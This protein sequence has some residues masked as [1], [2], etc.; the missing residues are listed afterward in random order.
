MYQICDNDT[1][2]HLTTATTLRDAIEA[3]IT[4]HQQYLTQLRTNGEGSTQ[5]RLATRVID[6]QTGQQVLGYA[7]HPANATSP[8][9]ATQ[10][11]WHLRHAVH[12][13]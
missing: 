11:G 4:R 5:A 12:T 9:A 2:Q 3:V 13:G 8:T 10:L 1:G 6:D 7:H